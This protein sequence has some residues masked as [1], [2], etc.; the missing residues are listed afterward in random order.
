[1]A[2]PT[3]PSD[4]PAASACSWCSAPVAPG[5]ATCSNCGAILISDE[6]Q[7]VPGV[8]AVDAKS[9]ARTKQATTGSRNRLLSWINGD[10]QADP[11]EADAHA[12]APPDADVQREIL[13]LELE[14]QVANL[15]AEAD[16]ILAE[17]AADGRIIDVPEELQTL[18]ATGGV[19]TALE[20]A[21][22]EDAQIN[23]SEA[24][25]TAD[26]SATADAAAT[27]DATTTAEAT[28]APEI[29]EI[30]DAEPGEA[31]DGATDLPPPAK[32]P[33]RPRLRRSK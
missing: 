14:A 21:E 15:Q 5:A 23:G 32:K 1:M 9:F 19:T 13:R 12:V 26:A 18:A 28:E 10:Y 27:A 33:R 22:A 29:V 2:D 25:A 30:E 24:T 20:A 17:A 3:P 8:T 31:G 11:S 7:E 16:A 4:A 6:E